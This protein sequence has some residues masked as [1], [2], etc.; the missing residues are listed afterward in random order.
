MLDSA[1]LFVFLGTTLVILLTPG[2]AVLYIVA[3]TLDQGRRAGIV[4]VLGIALGTLCHIAAATLGLS[5]ILMRSVLAFQLVRY[6]GAAYLLWIGI[7][8]LR[9]A[10]NAATSIVA[11]PPEALS[12]IFRNGFIVNLLNPKTT[13]FFFAFLPQF[14]RPSHGSV[15]IQILTLSL[16]FMAIG[17]TTD[18]MYALAA[19]RASSWLRGNESFARRSNYVAGTV[20]LGL[21]VAA[22]ATGGRSS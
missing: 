9:H 17:M 11:P 18:S 4:S 10:R 3:R 20:Y 13:L 21:G 12:R 14:I 1:A 19:G 8:K 16:L 15:T 22:A 5:A 2:P 7:Q 6:A